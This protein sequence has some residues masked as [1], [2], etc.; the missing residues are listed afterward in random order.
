MWSDRVWCNYSKQTGE[1]EQ[2]SCV[3]AVVWQ[4]QTTKPTVSPPVLTD[5]KLPL[6][7][8]HISVSVLG[9][10][11]VTVT[12]QLH[13]LSRQDIVLKERGHSRSTFLH[14]QTNVPLCRIVFIRSNCN[15]GEFEK[16]MLWWLKTNLRPL[17]PNIYRYIFSIFL[18]FLKFN[19]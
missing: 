13:K 19:A 9:L 10:D 16:Q 7:S 2:Y 12:H 15:E 18:S 4:R 1:S 8:L 11:G 3:F 6:Y 5:F 14:I 17:H